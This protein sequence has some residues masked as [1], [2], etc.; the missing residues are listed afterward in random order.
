MR[1]LAFI[2]FF[3]AAVLAFAAG[4]TN[5]FCVVCGKG[6]LTGHFWM[7]KWGALCDDCYHLKD[8]CSICGLPIKDGDGHIQTPDG[9]LICR[10]DKTNAVLDV[11]DAKELFADTRRDVVEMYGQGFGLQYPDVTVMMFD[12]DYWSEKNGANGLHKFGFAS[13]RKTADG[14]CTHEVVMLSGRTRE[15]MISVAAHEYTHLW[16]NENRPDGRVIESDTIEAICELTAYNLMGEKNLP[17]MQKRILENPYTEG[18]IK[19]LVAVYQEHDIGYILNWVKNGTT[20]T[21]DAATDSADSTVQ[22]S[23]EKTFSSAPPKLPAGLKFNGLLTI[24][25]DNQAVINGV[26]FAA[27]DEKHLKLRDKTVLVHCDEI[28]DYTVVVELD[29]SPGQIIL[30][31]DVEKLIP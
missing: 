24:G 17:E 9:R 22:F 10:F 18:R 15:E 27:G 3:F 14:T 25:K 11:D 20:E 4:E 26:S 23:A 5:Y 21:L 28:H 12:V 7:T 8:H 30:Q 2:F 31:R 6:P 16:I 1:R 19:T 13:T 29:G